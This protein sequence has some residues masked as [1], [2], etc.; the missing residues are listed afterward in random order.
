MNSV[1]HCPILEQTGDGIPCGRCWFFLKDGK[2]CP[3]HGDVSAEVEIYQEKTM[4]TR[5]DFRKKKFDSRM[6]KKLRNNEDQKPS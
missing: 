6:T 3:R 2:T 5:E 4:L 1:H